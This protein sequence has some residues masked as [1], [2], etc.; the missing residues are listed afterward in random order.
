MLRYALLFFPLMAESLHASPLTWDEALRRA[1]A[2]NP[3]LRASAARLESANQTLRGTYGY[4]LPGVSAEGGY[5][6]TDSGET[7]SLGLAGEQ[8]LFRGLGDRAR[9]DR[10]AF[11]RESAVQ[12]LRQARADVG[13]DLTAAFAG[14]RYA[15]DAVVL[16]QE[17]IR[18]RG[19]NLDV[20]SLRFQGG[21]E[22]K[23]SVLLF[24]AYLEQA[25]LDEWVASNQIA[26]SRAALARAIGEDPDE[27]LDVAGSVPIAPLVAA[28]DF[29]ALSRA[30]PAV[31]RSRAQQEAAKTDIVAA[32][33]A[34]FPTLDL[35]ASYGVAEDEFFP[36][37][38]VWRWSATF[39][40]PLFDGGRDW[41]AVK[42]ARALFEAALAGEENARREAHAALVR[43][44]NAFG[45]ADRRVAVDGAF[46]EAV[47]VRSDIS[48]HR[49]NNGLLTFE[50]WDVIE[51][52][53]INR[54]RNLLASVR[55]RETAA[56]A[57][58][59]AQGD[60]PVKGNP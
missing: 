15:R 19:E 9:T 2:Q 23:G 41:R 28:P 33:A 59:Q 16:Q 53:L 51:N 3:E 26:S 44:Y 4:F 35:R 18:R 45:E 12:D 39:D 37:A 29:A 57:W 58:R 7:Y 49:Y 48:R 20:V 50:D 47:R 56:A 17:I 5:V 24:R 32:R 14:F 38:D 8:N 40:L 46:L 10:A 25:K 21:R 13:Y 42:S 27:A 30:T 22:N 6:R 55:D 11:E 34:F 43:A 31:L 52:D 60:S 1:S 54:Q 36:T